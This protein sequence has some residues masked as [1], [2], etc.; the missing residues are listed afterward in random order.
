MSLGFGAAACSERS[1]TL[2]LT[3][4]ACVC[5]YMRGDNNAN[6]MTTHGD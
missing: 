3:M 2:L 5:A 4:R 1:Q 6:G